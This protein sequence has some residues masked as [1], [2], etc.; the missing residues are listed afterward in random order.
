MAPPPHMRVPKA[1]DLHP[2]HTEHQPKQDNGFHEVWV[3]Q[4]VYYVVYLERAKVA[5]LI[6]VTV[7]S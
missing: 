6:W 7:L 1:S 3:W 2:T 4:D 5:L